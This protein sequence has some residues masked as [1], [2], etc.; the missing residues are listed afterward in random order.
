MKLRVTNKDLYVDVPMFN[1]AQHYPDTIRCALCWQDFKG[2]LGIK[3][4]FILK[5]GCPE[6][7]RKPLKEKKSG[8]KQFRFKD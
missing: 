3:N 2:S 1:V 4:H 8:M 7:L 6:S 5:P